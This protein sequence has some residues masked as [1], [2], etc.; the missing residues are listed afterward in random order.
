M[1][2]ITRTRTS[3]PFLASLLGVGFLF[4]TGC[5]NPDPFLSES[6]E[7]ASQTTSQAT[8]DV[9]EGAALTNDRPANSAQ[10]EAQTSNDRKGDEVKAVS[11]DKDATS[12]P[13]D[14]GPWFDATKMATEVW[15][16]HYQG[17][18]PTGVTRRQL[19]RIEEDASSLLKLEVN[20][21]LRAKAGMEDVFQEMKLA[22]I[23]K[24]DG[25]LVSFDM[26]IKA[27]EEYSHLAGNVSGEQLKIIR[28]QNGET[29]QSRLP[30]NP[31][32]RGP[33]A[34][35]Q[36]LMRKP[37]QPGEIRQFAYLDPVLAEVIRVRLVA[38]QPLVNEVH[39]GSSKTLF[40]VT[41][42]HAWSDKTKVELL[43]VDE[44]GEIWK[45][46]SERQ[47]KRV[48]RCDKSSALTIKSA[49]E[50]EMI[51]LPSLTAGE[52]LGDPAQYE[53]ITYGIEA[54]ETDPFELFSR[55]T[56]QQLRSLTAFSCEVSVFG[57]RPG[58]PLPLGVEVESAPD[59][60]WLASNSYLQKEE[61]TVQALVEAML[62]EESKGPAVV[63]LTR[64]IHQRLAKKSPTR[65]FERAK[66]VVK[67]MAGDSTEHAVLLAT[68]ARM[69][70]IPSRLAV[71]LLCQEV[72]LTAALQ[73]HVWTE[74]WIGDRWI[75]V[76]SFTGEAPAPPNRV[77]FT[78]F[79]LR[80]GNPYEVMLS[81]AKTMRQLK[82]QIQKTERKKIAGKSDISATK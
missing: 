22:T 4:A 74:V 52:T 73:L 77:K 11:V 14:S 63:R 50:W 5:N 58:I 67:N 16:V 61:P 71:G 81:A 41:A 28:N 37:M 51:S 27:G 1:A 48:F 38:G 12:L 3:F 25:E 54:M 68:A 57:M 62:A 31:S 47:D 33:L 75:P 36:S 43:W 69:Q 82:V 35:E 29:K 2:R 24:V 15:T 7:S 46:Y 76:D 64:A 44:R 55:R 79:D 32:I 45:N 18:I 13:S 70:G 40:E 17:N 6:K 9:V 42:T 59:E 60:T 39:D 78:E 53:Q 21:T 23:E 26:Q 19:A 10:I 66:E 8:E 56:N 49:S 80:D 34:V 65:D 72:E 20:E 30:W